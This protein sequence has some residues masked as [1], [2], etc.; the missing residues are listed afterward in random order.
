MGLTSYFNNSVK[1]PAE[2]IEVQVKEISHETADVALI[3]SA[4]QNAADITEEEVRSMVREA[5]KLAG[6]LESIVKDGDFVV[7]K[8]NLIAAK[9]FAGGRFD[10]MREGDDYT[11]GK[12]LKKTANGISTDYRITKVVAEMVRELNPSG[13]IYIMESSGWGSTE[14]NMQLLGYTKENFPVVDKII[15]MDKVGGEYSSVDSDD[16]VALDLG[17]KKLYKDG[18]KHKKYTKGLFYMSKVYH[19]ADVVIDLPVLKSHL[20]AGFTGAV[21]NVAIGTAPVTVYGNEGTLDRFLIS[22]S[23]GPLNK[24]IHDFYLTK[25]VDF[26]IT[27]G[28]QGTENG[29]MAFA[30][31][32]LEEAQKNMRLILAGKDALAVDVI[33]AYTVGIDPQRVDYLTL[34]ANDK[35]GI[36]DPA[37]INVV[38]NARV[39]E[40]KKPFGLPGAPYSIFYPGP[41]KKKYKDFEAPE[42]NVQNAKLN[43]NTLTADL[44]SNEPV[45]KLDMYID[46][47]F[48]KTVSKSGTSIKLN[49]SDNHLSADSKIEVL[50]YDRFLNCSKTNV[51]VN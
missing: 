20:N 3:R 41:K 18:R 43:N 35:V 4:K 36:I 33:H 21:K 23:W 40:V 30:S 49:F 31:E 5:V 32:S 29:P 34:L 26:V 50:A 1:S 6:G 17:N 19:S 38:G 28:L 44:T 2:T 9:H 46:G 42:V 16:L 51:A 8:P 15:S 13:K 14:K 39:D 22:H 12:M 48:A 27:D 47:K 10:M 25:P 37:K 7:L 45:I 24:F 11:G